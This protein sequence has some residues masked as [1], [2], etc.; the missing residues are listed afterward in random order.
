MIHVEFNLSPTILM[1]SIERSIVRK[2]VVFPF[3]SGLILA[4][5]VLN[6]WWPSVSSLTTPI[7]THVKG[8]RSPISAPM[9]PIASVSTR[10]R[11]MSSV[12]RIIAFQ[13]MI[14]ISRLTVDCFYKSAVFDIILYIIL[15][16]STTFSS[17]ELIFIDWKDLR[18]NDVTFNTRLRDIKTG[19]II[20][21]NI[22]S[23]Y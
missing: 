13:L 17:V 2:L 11:R 10:I 18:M 5:P 19:N 9:T 23:P 20:T 12:T 21:D 1:P 4:W 7:V 16:T 8:Y 15:T 22:L 14:L 3:P 6:S